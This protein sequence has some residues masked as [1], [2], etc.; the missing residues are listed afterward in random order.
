MLKIFMKDQCAK[1]MVE[2]VNMLKILMKD[3]CAKNIVKTSHYPEDTYEGTMCQKY[4]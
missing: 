3:Q 2:K 4:S 1:T